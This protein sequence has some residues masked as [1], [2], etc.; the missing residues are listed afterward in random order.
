MM[1]LSIKRGLKWSEIGRELGRSAIQCHTWYMS[2]DPK[3]I[4]TPLFLLLK[5]TC[6]G[7]KP[8]YR[9]AHPQPNPITALLP[10]PLNN[11][12]S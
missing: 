10:H 2:R 12:N 5:I 6:M 7:T 1:E 9:L 8:N 11:S 3:V 4:K